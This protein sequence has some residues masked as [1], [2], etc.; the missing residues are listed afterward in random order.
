MKN[1]K[2]ELELYFME[3][4]KNDKAFKKAWEEFKVE[5]ETLLLKSIP[6]ME[7]SIIKGHNI[8]IKDCID[9]SKVDF[10]N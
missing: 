5:E 2:D 8:G 10:N 7:E 1:N 9:E 3:R 4:E 6:G